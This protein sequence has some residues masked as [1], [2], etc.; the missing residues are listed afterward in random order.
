MDALNK[1]RKIIAASD[2]DI[3]RGHFW[4]NSLNTPGLQRLYSRFKA[5]IAPK[6]KE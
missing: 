2:K 6:S 3:A 1:L 5:F 4:E